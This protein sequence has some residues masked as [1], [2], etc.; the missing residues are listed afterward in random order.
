[1]NGGP[2]TDLQ[3]GDSYTSDGT[4][5][6]GG[7]DEVHGADGGDAGAQCAPGRCDDLFY[8]DDYAASCGARW[9]S[10]PATSGGGVDLLTSD[11]GND[12]LN[13]GSPNDPELRGRGDKCSGGSSQDTAT[14][15]EYVYSDVEVVLPFQ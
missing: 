1:V 7:A 15:C 5:V 10:C 8:G 11:Q 14:R 12:F 9:V 4:A 13:G 6:G 3:V 2:G